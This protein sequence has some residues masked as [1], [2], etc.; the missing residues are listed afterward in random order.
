M[1]DIDIHHL[2]AAYALDA[3]DDRERAA[4]EAHYASCEVCHSDVL[5]FR[6]TVA[7]LAGA[8][9]TPPPAGLKAKVLSEIST[10]RQL[11]PL[12]PDAVVDLVDRRRRQ[13]RWT[14]SA[15]AAAAVVVAFVAG[16]LVVDRGGNEPGYAAE[17]ESVLGQPDGRIVTLAGTDAGEG[18]GMVRVAWSDRLD[19]A[20]LLADGLPA[21]P[22]GRAYELWLIGADG[23]VAMGVLDRAGD[24]QLREVLDVDAVPDA[25]GVTIEPASGSPT[26]TGDVLYLGEA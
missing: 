12:L 21:A 19:A 3:L 9:S 2:A 14:M 6:A 11:S 23:P 20:V 8:S 13:R 10:T 24:G 7:S 26:P 5:D 1:S 22:E 25:W 18:A 16:A 4:F 15:V 17:L